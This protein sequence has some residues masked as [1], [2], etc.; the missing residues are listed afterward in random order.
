MNNESLNQ[1]F[2][3]LWPIIKSIR[4]RLIAPV[5]TMG[6]EA[7]AERGSPEGVFEFQIL[8]AALLSSQTKDA[9]T[10]EAMSRLKELSGNY[11]D[12]DWVLKASVDQIA[13]AIRPVGF[14]N[15]KAKYLKSIANILNDQYDKHVPHTY[16]ELIALPGIG[17]KMASLILTCAFNRNDSICVDTHVHRITNALKWGCQKC[18]KCKHVQHTRLALQEWLPEKFWGDYSL[19]LVGLGQLL[20]TKKNK[21]IKCSEDME[22]KDEAVKL[23]NKLGIY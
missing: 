22:D 9:K 20:Q 7:L 3:H 14:Y 21:L 2:E 19:T 1:Q 4:S 13:E 11:L 18:K 15:Q 6:C 17:P 16:R 8:I 12:I 10:A 5:D 23:L